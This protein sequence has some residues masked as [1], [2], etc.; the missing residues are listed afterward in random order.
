MDPL[1]SMIEIEVNSQCNRTCW[2]CPNSVT[3]RK[4]NGEMDPVLYE[5]LMRQLQS[6][7]FSGR[8]SFHF[9]GEPLLCS[10]IDL[11]VG[12]TKTYI[13]KAKPIMYTNGDLL[14]RNRVETL[15]SLGLQKFI[16]TQ[17]VG[18]KHKFKEVYEQLPEEQQQA[19][20]YLH[21]SDLVL[22]NRGGIL[23]RIPELENKQHICMVPS[24]L[25]VVT[26]QGNVLPCFEDFHQ[27]Y[28]MGNIN[29]RHIRD[30]WYGGEFAAFRKMLK[31]GQ[32]NKSEICKSCNNISVQSTAEYDYVL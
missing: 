25:A 10:N 23:S 14:D 31:E 27:K 4:E 29:D 24:T 11:F 22:S 2:Y 1:F 19:I 32:R 13:P 30:I 26:V 20:V 28:T 21:H 12:L 9:Y 5:K 17:H 15:L 18:A 6:I 3:T 7:D 16:V 8:L